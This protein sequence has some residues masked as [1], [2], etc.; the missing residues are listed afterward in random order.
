MSH[1]ESAATCRNCEAALTGPYCAACGQKAEHLHRPFW[2][3]LEDFLHTVIHFDGRLWRTL[4]SLF[5]RPG[6]MTADWAD[7]RQARYMPPIR[8]FIFTSLIL[9][10]VLT[11][12]DVAL[13]RLVPQGNAP[14][15]TATAP[16]QMTLPGLGIEFLSLTPDAAATPTIDESMADH[17][18][19]DA[20]EQKFAS[21]FV[22]GINTLA[23]D[24]HLSNT[25][26]GK[27]LGRF[28]LLAV[29]VMATLLW[30]LY[31]RQKR[32]LAEHV[33][34]ALNIHTFFFIGLLIAVALQWATRGLLPGKWV[35]LALWLGYSLHFLLALKRMYQQSWTTTI[36]K[37]ALITGTY[38]VALMG[39][40]LYLLIAAM[41][42]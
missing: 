4:R 22:T 34:F 5:L 32:Y 24:P 35:L 1:E 10:T 15:A 41:I 19:S 33:V 2:E 11:L 30:L 38:M 28:M 7:G 39:A 31:L 42:S 25:V 8:L 27:S 13:L 23:R 21:R 17:A 20:T 12:S 40:G 9:V 18:S 29:P 36:I 6:E 37:S 26:I 16:G 3:I 14:A